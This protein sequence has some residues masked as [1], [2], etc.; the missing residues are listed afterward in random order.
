MFK[1][2]INQGKPI[3]LIFLQQIDLIVESIVGLI[4]G[5]IV[6]SIVGLIVG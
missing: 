5:S 1:S 6:G 2:N 4:I 3:L